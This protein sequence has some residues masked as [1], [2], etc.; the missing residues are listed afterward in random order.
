[1]GRVA[2]GAGMPDAADE[3]KAMI[4]APAQNHAP[5]ERAAVALP[6]AEVVE[7]AE[8][9]FAADQ[10]AIKMRQLGGKQV[11]EGARTGGGCCGLLCAFPLIAAAAR[12]GQALL[13]W[14]GRRRLR[15]ATRSAAEAAARRQPVVSTSPRAAASVACS[16]RIQARRA[17]ASRATASTSAD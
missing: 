3:G 9:A 1:G 16:R 8:D 6:E 7:E 17:A 2:R 10:G 14:V 11:V 12:H 5:V 15:R 13:D 4:A